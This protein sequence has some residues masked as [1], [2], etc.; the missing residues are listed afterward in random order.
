MR[1]RRDVTALLA[2]VVALSMPVGCSGDF[3]QTHGPGGTAGPRLDRDG[4]QRG[5][6]GPNRPDKAPKVLRLIG[7][8]STSD[9]GPQPHQPKAERLAPGERPP[10]FVVFSWDG[11]GQDKQKLFSHFRAV[12][13]K[14]GA[15]MTYFLSG[16]YLLPAEKGYLYDPP[17]HRRGA[18]TIGFNDV[19]GI[20]ATVEQLSGA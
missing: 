1:A 7:D 14:Y 18:S 17:R 11:A 20:K 6:G 10:R 15:T 16:V 4:P 8:G 9:T 13:R 19:K 12:G 3:A 2:M 5:P